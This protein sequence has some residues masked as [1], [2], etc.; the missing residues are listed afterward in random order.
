MQKPTVRNALITGA[1]KRIGRAMALDLAAHGWA[2]AV[3]YNGSEAAALEVCEEIAKRGGRAAPVKANLA[4]EDDCVD[5][6][7]RAVT[8]VGPLNCLINNASIFE[9]DSPQTATRESWEAHM[10]INLRAPFVLIQKFADQVS[11][12]GP[13]NVINVIDQRV[14]KLTGVLYVLYGQQGR[15]VDPDTDPRPGPGATDPGQCGRSRP[16]P[17]QRPPDR[18]SVPAPM[19]GGSSGPPASIRRKFAMPSASYLTRRR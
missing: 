6:V 11:E 2:V 8:A 5:L 18:R 3:H 4:H 1:A 12:S 16:H 13:A 7:A 15:P 14:W 9:K 19:A 17:A 10:Q